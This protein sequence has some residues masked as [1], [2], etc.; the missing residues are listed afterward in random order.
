MDKYIPAV[1][2][3]GFRPRTGDYFFI[4]LAMQYLI[5]DGLK[6]FRPRTGDYFFIN[7]DDIHHMDDCT[8]VCFRPRTGDYFFIYDR[9]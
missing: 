5:A 1:T 6:G 7:C 2:S 9:P 8:I 3:M 4:R